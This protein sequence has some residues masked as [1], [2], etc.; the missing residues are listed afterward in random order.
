MVE[1]GAEKGDPRRTA[2]TE[3][4]ILLQI[5]EAI[6]FSET[7]SALAENAREKYAFFCRRPGAFFV[8]AVMAGAFI[9]LGSI[10]SLSL[11]GM[12]AAA[13]CAA[14]KLLA[15]L[16]FASA[17]SLVIMAG[18]NLFTGNNLTVGMGV[19]SGKVGWGGALRLWGFC[20]LGNL[21]GCWLFVLL[22]S[23]A[24]L[25]KNPDTAAYIA[26]VAAGKMSAA[27]FA[28]FVK[29]LLCNIC[30][31]LAVWCSAKLKSETAVLI[32]AVWCILIFMLS[33]F[34]HSIANMAILGLALLEGAPL[35]SPAAYAGNILLVTLGNFVGGFVFV[36]VP[37]WFV[38]ME[39]C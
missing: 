28:L 5:V 13:G 18:C 8:S 15:A 20:W 11:G 12:L 3:Y 34:E 23:A 38:S 27:P 30:V 35:V 7:C 31:C 9:A 25:G 14:V 39:K 4:R 22:Y 19:L 10:V 6:M 16:V 21:A 1:S 26:A 37:Y 29:A 32:M 33:G 17:L 2:K 24:G 36:A